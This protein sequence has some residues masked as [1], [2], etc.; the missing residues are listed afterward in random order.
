MAKGAMAL[1]DRT[2]LPL[3]PPVS[4]PLAPREELVRVRAGAWRLLLPMR[5][6][7]RVLGAA[8]PAARPSLG[9]D[10]PPVVA[11][12][13]SLVPL[14]FARALLGAEEVALRAEDQMVLLRIDGRRAL[15]WV[16]AVEEVVE[17]SPVEPPPGASPGAI[18]AA[19]SGAGQPL[20]VLD[21]PRL[22][23]SAA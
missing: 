11:V 16:D 22:L 10:A 2:Q 18:V 20:A 1:D 13:R 9:D 15:L 17:F 7:E 19:F 6:V 23:E 3:A 14:L 21:V 12:G 4:V 8:L 5:F